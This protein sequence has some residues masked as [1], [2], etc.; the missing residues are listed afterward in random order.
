MSDQQIMTLVILLSRTLAGT[1]SNSYT[2]KR[3]KKELTNV[4]RAK[5]KR[6]RGLRP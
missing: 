2:N 3:S 6:I 1:T 5:L 4:L